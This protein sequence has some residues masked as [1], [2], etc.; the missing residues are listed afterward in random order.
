MSTKNRRLALERQQKRGPHSGLHHAEFGNGKW[1]EFKAEEVE[2]FQPTPA[3]VLRQGKCT[4]NRITVSRFF[5]KSS[6]PKSHHILGMSHG[7]NDGLINGLVSG[8]VNGLVS[9]LVNG[10]VSG[11]VSG[12]VNG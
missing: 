4:T 11:L 8:L 10:L 3:L 2:C 9:G 12:L 7:L 5:P 6:T 1:D